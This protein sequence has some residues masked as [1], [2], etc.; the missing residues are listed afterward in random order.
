[1]QKN[2]SFSICSLLLCFAL[3]LSFL[4]SACGEKS[5]KAP[6]SSADFVGKNYKEVISELKQAGFS[7]IETVVIED[8]S[9]KSS[10]PDEAVEAVSIGDIEDFQIGDTFSP[11]EKIMVTYHIIKKLNPPLSSDDIQALGHTD[12]QEKFEAA[13]FA[14]VYTEE[15]FDLD[16]DNF[17]GEYKNEVRIDSESSF[18]SFDS[19]PFDAKVSIICHRPYEKYTLQVHVDCTPNLIFSKYD[20]DIFLDNIKQ[21]TLAHGSDA[22]YSF[23]VADGS[24]T[25]TFSKPDAPSINGSATIDAVSTDIAASYKLAC[26][27]DRVDVKSVYIDRNVV[28]SED[29]IKILVPASE[30]RFKDYK[31]VEAALSNL[32]FTNIKYNILYDIVFGF[33]PEGEVSDVTI[34]GT[35]DFTCGTVFPSDAE[36]IIT[37][38]MSEDDDPSNISMPEDNTHYVGKDYREVEQTFKNLG[39]TNISC[40]ETTISDTTHLDG[41]V[42]SVRVDY[43]F[44]SQGSSYKPTDK[45][46]IKY[47]IVKIPTQTETPAETEPASV[48]YSTNDTSTVKNGNTGIYAYRN[49]GGQYYVY[50]IIDFDN[51]YVYYFTDSEGGCIKTKIESGTLNDVLIITYHDG[52]M[53]WSEGLHFKWKN[54]PDHLILQDSDGFEYDFYTTD[55][56]DALALRDSKTIKDY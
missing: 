28:L 41:E 7:N 20:I 5:P 53:E 16:P 26:Y 15:V 39:F 9:S 43:E 40:E 32:G 10:I 19:Y 18:D 31:D 34:N 14:H 38:H 56:E 4:F 11:Q 37:Y 36:V 54:Q 23:R 1:M 12:I 42:C 3:L 51:G 24:H 35:N 29:E 47:Y 6:A 50:F 27:S 13:G 17:V 21:V 49:R 46:Q 44:F 25:L 33:T 30:Y 22:D 55:L 52:D 8:L 2:L 48:S 45:V